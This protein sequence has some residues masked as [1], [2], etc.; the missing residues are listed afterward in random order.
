MKKNIFTHLFTLST[1]LLLLTS[2]GDFV[3]GRIEVAPEND[4]RIQHKIP[5][6]K[7]DLYEGKKNEVPNLSN[8]DPDGAFANWGSCYVMFKEGHDHGGGMMHG[9]YV[10]DKGPWPQEMFLEVFNRPSGQVPEIVLD[11]KSI[12]T[13]LENERKLEAPQHIRLVGGAKR[14]WGLLLNFFDKEGNLMNDSILKHSGKYQIFYSISDLDSKGQPYEVMDV[15]WRGE[16]QINPTEP[17]LYPRGEEPIPSPFF[18]GAKTLAERQALTRRIFV[19]TYRDTW[20]KDDMAD[21]V[22]TFFNIKLLPPLTKEDQEVGY[23]DI[24]CVGLKGHFTFNWGWDFDGIE[25]KKWVEAH[26]IK[27]KNGAF[28]RPYTRDT[29]LL[30]QFYLAVRVMKRKDGNKLLVPV[31]SDRNYYK[32]R[33]ENVMECSPHVAPVDPDG[34]EEII[35]FNIPIRL[36]A[37]SYDSDPT[38]DHP[39]EPFYVSIAKEVRVTPEEAY[40]LGTNKIILSNDGS[41]G[42]GYGSFFL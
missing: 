7:M 5:R 19:Y 32:V 11:G 40:E 15:R 17:P 29:H 35:R 30:P 22:H 24:D 20:R 3:F 1:L 12:N 2:C 33:G 39:Y 16:G 28:F 34:W 10:Y 18:Q 8:P 26:R 13:Y 41:G 36:F 25:P 37:D 31:S 23:C 6:T 21:G 14:R 42:Q 38:N 4:P 9:N 27:G